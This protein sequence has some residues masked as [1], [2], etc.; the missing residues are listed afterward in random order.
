MEQVASTADDTC[1]CRDARSL[2]IGDWSLF[3]ANYFVRFVSCLNEQR[4]EMKT[5]G[6]LFLMRSLAIVGAHF[7]VTWVKLRGA[8][9]VFHLVSEF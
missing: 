3:S 5:L 1:R 6:L 8:F 4:G 7:A 9:Q 2:Q